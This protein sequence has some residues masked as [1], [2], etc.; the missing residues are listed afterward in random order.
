MSYSGTTLRRASAAGDAEVV[1]A[2]LN[3][4]IK[5]DDK[6]ELGYTALHYA[7]R[8]DKIKMENIVTVLVDHGADVNAKTNNGWSGLNKALNKA[9]Q[10][11]RGLSSLLYGELR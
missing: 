10:I 3:A 7:C 9:P 5:V 1:L 8:S 11:L 2:N 6:D 4:G